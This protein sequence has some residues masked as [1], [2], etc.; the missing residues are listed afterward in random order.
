ME[1]F[2]SHSAATVAGLLSSCWQATGALH[3]QIT[4]PG[5]KS[6]SVATYPTLSAHPE[7]SS[8]PLKGQ[9]P[10][11]SQLQCLHPGLGKGIH[12]W[13]RK[14]KRVLCH[15]GYVTV[16]IG[17]VAIGHLPGSHLPRATKTTIS[18]E[19]WANSTK[20]PFWGVYSNAGCEQPCTD[21]VYSKSCFLNHPKRPHSYQ[22]TERL[23]SFG[24]F[25]RETVSSQDVSVRFLFQCS[26]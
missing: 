2:C 25:Q 8:L 22:D 11:P 26:A 7:T 6:H 1:G 14:K 18:H 13:L 10:D 20:A 24:T 5:D 9:L 12:T 16:V 4:F 3:P 19:I 21:Y 17:S 15:S 23:N